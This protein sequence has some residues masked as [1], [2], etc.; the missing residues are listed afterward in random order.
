MAEDGIT[1][2]SLGQKWMCKQSFGEQY[3]KSVV[4]IG[5][6]YRSSDC[7]DIPDDVV[8]IVEEIED[9]FDKETLRDD[10]LGKT[11]QEELRSRIEELRKK[12][13]ITE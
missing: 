10:D 5:F 6:S 1:I 12:L 7:S 11:I 4:E 9:E 13:A 2:P 8:D 3:W